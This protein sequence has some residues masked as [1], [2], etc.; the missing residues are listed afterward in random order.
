[1]SMWASIRDT[2][3]RAFAPPVPVSVMGARSGV[4]AAYAGQEYDAEHALSVMAAYSWGAT[5]LTALANDMSSL[6]IELYDADGEP[7]SKHWFI[8]LMRRPDPEWS[9][10]RWRRQMAVDY[11]GSGNAYARKWR[12][13]AG[14]LYRL[15]RLHPRRMVRLGDVETGEHHG[16]VYDGRIHLKPEDVLVFA[17]PGWRDDPNLENL[18]ESPIR[19]LGTGIQSAID[20]RKQAGKAARRGRHEFIAAPKELVGAKSVRAFRDEVEA[21]GQRGDA[22]LVVDRPWDIS[23]TSLT[24]R[25]TEWHQLGIDTRDETLGRFGVPPVRAGMA[26]ANYGES[27]QQM[28]LYWQSSVMPHTVLW[29]AEFTELVVAEGMT[30]RHSYEGVEALQTSLTERLNRVTVWVQLGATPYEAAKQEGFH[31]PPL[32]KGAPP[33]V[34]AAKVPARPELSVETPQARSELEEALARCADAV[35][36]FDDDP[37]GLEMACTVALFPVMPRTAAALASDIA[38]GTAGALTTD[39]ARRLRAALEAA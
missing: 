28:R 29:D 17:Q 6:P 22:A 10:V 14:R 18:G 38:A 15:Q 37:E 16:W 23:Q 25:D 30:V 21:S 36:T 5:A 11:L 31:E 7:V 1:M 20:A 12:T 8:D 34:D 9:G 24:A 3:A 13:P 39:Y 35:D 2:I 32:T 33:R 27:K 4:A 19:A 26:G